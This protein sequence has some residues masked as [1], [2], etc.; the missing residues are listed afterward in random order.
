M[1][2]LND[3]QRLFV[4]AMLSEPTK[5]A[6]KWARMAGYS[7]VKEGAKVRGHGLIHNPKVKAAA[8]EVARGQLDAR[9]PIV[10]VEG[11]LRIAQ[12]P[13][14]KKHMTALL[15]IL[16]RV[17]LP[18]TTEHTVSVLHTDRTG[19]ALAARIHELAGKLGMDA[20]WLL[21][22]NAAPRQIEGEVVSRETVPHDRPA[23]D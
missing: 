6:A 20:T 13:S 2:S 18:A 8:F 7:D 21:G 23:Q 1:R 3:R 12:R 16:D 11:L 10:A 14:H 22:V 4:L 15:A 9:G 17:G 5:D 19:K